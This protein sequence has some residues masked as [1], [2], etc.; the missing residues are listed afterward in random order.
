M[1]EN[2][3]LLGTLAGI[4]VNTGVTVESGSVVKI[5]AMLFVTFCL[6]MLAFYAFKKVNK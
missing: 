5:G 4:D 3:S 6:I 1:A 2:K